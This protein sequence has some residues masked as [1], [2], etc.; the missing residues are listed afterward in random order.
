[1]GPYNT[2]SFLLVYVH[3]KCTIFLLQHVQYTSEMSENMQNWKVRPIWVYVK[4][5]KVIKYLNFIN[6]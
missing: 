5:H 1:M 2:V 4:V 3:N 6:S